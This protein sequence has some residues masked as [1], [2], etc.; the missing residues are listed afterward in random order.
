M[1]SSGQTAESNEDPAIH[2]MDWPLVRAD[3]TGLNNETGLVSWRKKEGYKSAT[4][5][6]I[7]GKDG[8]MLVHHT[9]STRKRDIFLLMQ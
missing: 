6:S 5:D 2:F 8:E 9:I 1:I 4:G 3:N 7:Q